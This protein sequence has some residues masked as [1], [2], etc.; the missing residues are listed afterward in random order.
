[1]NE[2]YPTLSIGLVVYNGDNYLSTAIESILNQSYRDFELIISDNGSTDDTEEICLKYK[3]LDQRIKYFRYETNRGAAWNYNNVYSHSKGKYFKFLNHD[4]L[5]HPFY[6]EKCILKLENNPNAVLCYSKRIVI[7]SLGQEEDRIDD[8]L[9][10]IDNKANKRFNKFLKRFRYTT[11]W[12]VIVLGVIRKDALEKTDIMKDFSAADM[13]LLAQL[14]LKGKFLEIDDYLLYNR[15]HSQMSNKV[16][17]TTSQ[18][19]EF[20]NPKNKNK[21]CFPRWRWSVEFLKTISKS[22]ISLFQKFSCIKSV[23]IWIVVRSK[24]L[25]ADIVKAAEEYYNKTITK[26]RH[27]YFCNTSGEI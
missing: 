27:K 18:L 10:L 23:L 11:F 12:A 1:M 6:L 21:I 7:N 19:A 25:I 3:E 15:R 22:D 9:Q 5:Y 20:Y 4:D 26:N 8:N 14:V 2:R 16:N 17:T 24:S 13:I